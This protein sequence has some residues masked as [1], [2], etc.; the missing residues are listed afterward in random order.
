MTLSDGTPLDTA[1]AAANFDSYGLR[2]LEQNFRPS[3]VLNSYAKSEVID[4]LTVK[5]TFKKPSSGFLQGTSVIVSGLVAQATWPRRFDELGD[6]TK[7]IGPGS[8]VVESQTV[9][10]EIL[11]KAQ[12]DYNWAPKS[13]AHQ[14]RDCL[15]EIRLLIVPEDSVR[16]GALLSGQADVVRQIQAHVK[17]QITSAGFQL[18]APPTRGI[19]NSGVFLPDNPLVADVNVWQALL[20]GTDTKEIDVTIFSEHYPQETSILAWTAKVYVNLAYKLA[21]D[22]VL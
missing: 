11:F 7:V 19:N 4:P 22:P 20:H 12:E 3:D 16:I 2:K 13:F 15:D 17:A 5:F 9:G 1:A 10:P 8:F 14:G 6:A 21:F 18:F